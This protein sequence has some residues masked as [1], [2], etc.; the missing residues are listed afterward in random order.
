MSSLRCLCTFSNEQQVGDLWRMEVKG[1]SMSM[2][3]IGRKKLKFS[4]RWKRWSWKEAFF[5]L[6][7]GRLDCT[8][9]DRGNQFRLLE[10]ENQQIL[11]LQY[12]LVCTDEYGKRGQAPIRDDESMSWIYRGAHLPP[13]LYVE[14]AD[15]PVQDVGEGTTG[16]QY[17]GTGSSGVGGTNEDDDDTEDDVHGNGDEE[18]VPSDES[19][20]DYGDHDASS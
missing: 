20:D 4:F 12:V 2:E 14:V 1:G 17:D 16:G 6:K 9:Q 15:E 7:V 11:P 13:A 8:E 3:L 10:S 19:D 5:I 18:Y